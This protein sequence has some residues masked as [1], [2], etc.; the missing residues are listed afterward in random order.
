MDMN[1][2]GGMWEGGSG[3][4][5]VEWRGEEKLKKK[6]ENNTCYEFSNT[7]MQTSSLKPVIYIL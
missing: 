3:Q 5:G 7:V 2:R 1:Y 4:D 6:K